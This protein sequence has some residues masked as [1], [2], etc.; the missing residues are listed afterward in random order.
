M[1][2]NEF[3]KNIEETI[4]VEAFREYFKDNLTNKTIQNAIEFLSEE[5]AEPNYRVVYSGQIL[6][7]D[8]D[9]FRMNLNIV[10]SLTGE[11]IVAGVWFG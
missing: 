2:F 8:H 9:P 3:N 10:K 1:T 11:D 6:T 5:L 4:I 7:R